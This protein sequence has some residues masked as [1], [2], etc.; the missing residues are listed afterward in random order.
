MAT[1]WK[2]PRRRGAASYH[3]SKPENQ[4]L[5]KEKGKNGQRMETPLEGG[6]DASCP[7]INQTRKSIIQQGKRE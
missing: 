5:I 1:G 2:P 3:Q 6:M 4:S 7:S